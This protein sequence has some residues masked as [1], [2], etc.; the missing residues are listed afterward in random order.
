[1]FKKNALNRVSPE[2]VA[3]VAART[4]DPRVT[5]AAVL[6]GELNNHAL[7]RS[8]RAGPGALLLGRAVA[9]LATSSRHQR[10][11]RSIATAPARARCVAGGARSDLLDVHHLR[12]TCQ[13]HHV[14][15]ALVASIGG[16]QAGEL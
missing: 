7:Q 1:M 2:L 9:S 6:G 3:E 8:R 12:P 11:I 14:D 16:G 10:Q 15:A 13:A 4:T 5:P